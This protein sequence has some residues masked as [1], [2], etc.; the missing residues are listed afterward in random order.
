MNCILFDD[1][2]RNR[3]LPFTHTRPVADIRCGILTMRERWEL[4][5]QQPTSSLTINYLQK[6]FPLNAGADN[7]YINAAVFATP[8]LAAAI[9]QLGTGQALIKGA[10][11]LAFRTNDELINFENLSSVITAYSQ[12]H[13]SHE[14]YS[15]NHVWNIFSY[16]DDAIKNDYTLLTK[17]RTSQPIPNGVMVQGADKLFIEDGAVINAGCIIN[18][19][20]GPIYIGKDAEIM[21]GCLIRGPFAMCSHSVLKMGAKIY[22]ATTLGPGCKAGGEISNAVFFANSNKGHDGFLGN[23]VIGEWCNLGADTNCSNLKNNY[24]EVKIWDEYIN[25][26][27]RTGLTFCGLLMGDHSKCSINTMFNTGTIVGVSCNI[28]GSG[29]PEKFIPSFCWGG[30]DGLTTYKL[31][32]AMDTAGRMMARRDKTLS[33]EEKEIYRHIFDNT[34]TQRRIFADHKMN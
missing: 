29:F 23:A 17:G 4:C 18:A 30:S 19:E 8:Q 7:T 25:K 21:E 10:Q 12:Q 3:L 32:R 9:A 5:L 15:L 14:I 11:L 34:E 22:G 2:T 28:F 6:V 26:S 24:D 33:A 27:V 1:S 13:Y 16:N 20:T 31:D